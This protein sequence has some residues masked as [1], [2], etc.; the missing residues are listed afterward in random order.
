M[1]FGDRCTLKPLIVIEVGDLA[2]LLLAVIVADGDHRILFDDTGIDT[3]DAD[4]ADI[5]IISQGAYLHLQRFIHPVRIRIDMADDRFKQRIDVVVGITRIVA[6]DTASGD[7]IEDREIQLIII[8]IE[9]Q[10]KI[11]DLIDNFVDSGILLIDLVD[12]KNRSQTCLKRLLEDETGLRHRAFR[13]VDQQNDRIDRFDDTFDFTGEICVS[14]CIYNIDLVV[15]ID[16]RA[17][18]GIDRDA[19]FSLQIV[20]IHDLSDDLFMVGKDM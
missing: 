14:R 4:S 20:G 3:A 11:I 19:S 16:D 9:I 15:L 17:V 13:R 7:T 8:G 2:V 1:C 12:Q 6:D 5:V 10:E 18:F